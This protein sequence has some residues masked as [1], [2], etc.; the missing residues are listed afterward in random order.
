VRGVIKEP[1][2]KLKI[3]AISGKDLVSKDITGKSDPYLRLFY[4]GQKYKSN[5]VKK[6]IS[7]V[8]NE[9]FTFVYQPDASLIVQCYDRDLLENMNLWAS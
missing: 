5:T 7:P 2:A 8:W 3:K 4:A 6:S 1:K 9:E